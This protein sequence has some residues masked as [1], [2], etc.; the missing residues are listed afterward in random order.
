MSAPVTRSIG[1]GAI[2]RQAGRRRLAARRELPLVASCYLLAALIVTMWLWRDPASRVVAG[3]PAD[4]DQS[5]WWMR[6]AAEAIA[7]WHLPALIATGMNAP[8][9]VSAAWNPSILAPGVILSPVTLL[10]SPQV[11]LTVMLTAG[12]AGSAT[13]LYWVLR[14]WDVGTFAAVAGGL[15]YGFSPAITQ[16]SLGHYDLQFEVLPPL[17]AHLTARLVTGRGGPVRTGAAL[18]LVA[19]LQLFT[20]EEMLFYTAIAV[21][22]GLCVAA[23]SSGRREW[24][25]D[26]VIGAAAG[27][28]V[29]VGVFMLLA[30]YAL[31]TQFA[32]PLT[33]H[34]SPYLIDFYKNDLAGFVQPSQLQLV[35]SA[36][37]VAFADR[38]QGNLSEYLGYLG[39][40]MVLV[41]AWATVT[42]WR[43]LGARVLSVTFFVLEACS[44][45][46]V[47]LAGGHVHGWLKLPW[48]WLEDL[49]L[50]SSAI[51]D[52][53][54]LIADGCA[55]A[56]LALAIDAAWRAVRE[57]SPAMPAR[58]QVLARAA[59]VAATA[60][61]IGPMLPAP[62]PM[63]PVPGVPAG[64]AQT[65]R[66]L[67]LP[68]SAGVLTVPVPADSYTAPLRWQADTGLPAS[69]VGGYF[70]GPVQ[71]GQ[72]FVDAYGLS[73]TAQY[74]DWLWQDSGTGSNNPAGLQASGAVPQPGQAVAWIKAT[75]VSAV[76]AVTSPGSPLATYLTSLLGPPATHSGGVL[77]WAVPAGYGSQ[78]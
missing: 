9:G 72:A 62:L 36:G 70:I 51:V 64:W 77:G 73:K 69:M 27:L 12:F 13:S 30:G 25:I 39:W 54:S 74:L 44:L 37:S 59:V 45:G 61:A 5:A 75:Q 63:T 76:V 46:G 28:L 7:H 26:R 15:A 56:L 6:Y 34:G 8:T 40:P 68:A 4:P 19:A 67:R 33:Q 52:R 10:F 66:G 65:I 43:V 35:H 42:T 14:R 38:F 78:G 41:L 48:Y 32:G 50:A 18:G 57:A 11:S 21:V 22:V 49:P 17:I 20:A 60:I 29:A 24:G 1:P 16:A 58:R 23:V 31:W 3:N 71:G 53:F 55:A 2:T 47:L